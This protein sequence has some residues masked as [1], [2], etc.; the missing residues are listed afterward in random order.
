MPLSDPK[1]TIYIM[2]ETHQVPADLT[3]MG[4]LEYAGYHLIRE[5]GCRVGFCGSCKII[6]CLP[7]DTGFRT[8]LACSTM[9][10]EQMYIAPIPYVPISP[11][12]YDINELKPDI[13]TF[14]SIYPK[15]LHCIKCNSCTKA[16]PQNLK[17]MEY[18]Q[19]IVNNDIAKCTDLSIECV[20][21]GL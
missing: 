13:D 19:A 15:L 14:K 5:T 8:A 3:I 1:I 2:G 12:S 20:L 10:K 21:C 6:Y 9:V 16:C 11:H 17:V 4:A 7:G 18:I